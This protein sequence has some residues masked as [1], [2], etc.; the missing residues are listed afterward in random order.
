MCTNK[1]LLVIAFAFV[2]TEAVGVALV[3]SGLLCEP[4][5]VLTGLVAACVAFVL[6]MTCCFS[7]C[8]Q[9]C[10]TAQMKQIVWCILIALA[11]TAQSFVTSEY[12]E[13][14]VAHWAYAIDAIGLVAIISIYCVNE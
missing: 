3:H 14:A 10:C 7:I 11:A 6:I 12:C 1:L 5:F 2:A 9:L 4:K 8:W 13:P